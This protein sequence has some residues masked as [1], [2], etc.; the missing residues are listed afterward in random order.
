MR[1]DFDR[2][3]MAAHSCGVPVLDTFEGLYASGLLT[4]LKRQNLA[5]E[6]L[7][8]ALENELASPARGCAPRRRLLSKA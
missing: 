1:K 2:S 4:C 5:L 8:H 3:N 7:R 6:R